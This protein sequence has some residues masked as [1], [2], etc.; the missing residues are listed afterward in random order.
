MNHNLI[1]EFLICVVIFILPIIISINHFR[2]IKNSKVEITTVMLI[3]SSGFIT[4]FIAGISKSPTASALVPVISS[5]LAILLPAL[6]LKNSEKRSQSYRLNIIRAK[7]ISS[8]SIIFLSTL[9]ASYLYSNY[10]RVNCNNFLYK[11]GFGKNCDSECIKSE[12]IKEIR[13]YFTDST[14]YAN[15]IKNQV[16]TI[17]Q[18]VIQEH[19]LNK[20]KKMQEIL[21]QTIG[22][23]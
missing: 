10:L 16:F 22:C 15:G 9:L 14:Y 12:K 23:Q 5:S 17:D 7:N 8:L 3:I 19:F 4:G 11:Y 20:P 6:A 13:K 21:K 1:I 18:N 2:P